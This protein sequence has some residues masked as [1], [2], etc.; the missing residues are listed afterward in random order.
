MQTESTLIS[1]RHMLTKPTHQTSTK[2]Q[3]DY[4]QEQSPYIQGASDG[5]IDGTH[6]NNTLRYEIVYTTQNL[7]KA[8][9]RKLY[10]DNI[11]PTFS[12]F[13]DHSAENLYQ[14]YA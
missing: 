4:F 2:L 11:T 5:P 6:H 9:V 8:A 12:Y 13:S 10:C 1:H 7:C 3:L 14:L